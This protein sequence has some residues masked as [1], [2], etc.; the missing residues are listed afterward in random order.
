[1]GLRLIGRLLPLPLDHVAL[2]LPQDRAVIAPVE[3]LH[4]R[5]RMVVVVERQAR[6]EVEPAAA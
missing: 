2:D 5:L 6:R 3:I 1:V 4:D